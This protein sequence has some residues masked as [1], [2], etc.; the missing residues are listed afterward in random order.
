[1][2]CIFQLT[3]FVFIV[4][5]HLVSAL[6]EDQVNIFD[7]TSK[8]LGCP[9]K[10][11]VRGD[12]NGSNNIF[13]SS[14]N[15][16]G[17]IHMETGKLGWRH[18]NGLNVAYESDIFTQNQQLIHLLND[19]ALRSFDLNS[20][21]VNWQ[22]RFHSSDN[23]NEFSFTKLAH[24]SNLFAVLFRSE[25][26]YGTFS[27]KK[28]TSMKSQSLEKNTD[29]SDVHVYSNRI[30]VIGYKNEEVLQRSYDLEENDGKTK[31]LKADHP[32]NKCNFLGDFIICLSHSKTEKIVVFDINVD[33]AKSTDSLIA[34]PADQ[35]IPLNYGYF[36][37][38]SNKEMLVA[39]INQAKSVNVLMKFQRTEV[40]SITNVNMESR[41]TTILSTYHDETQTLRIYDLNA[42]RELGTWVLKNP[43]NP[44]DSATQLAPSRFVHVTFSSQN[45]VFKILIT[46]WDCRIDYYETNENLDHAILKWSR[47]EGLASINTVQM[48]DFPLSYAQA[49]IETEFGAPEESIWQSFVLRI[50]SQIEQFRH[51]IILFT[52]SIIK[53]L[54]LI[55]KHHMPISIV[56][57]RIFLPKSLIEKKEP[58]IFLHNVSDSERTYSE[59]KL[60]YNELERDFFNTRKVI[61]ATTLSGSLYGINNENG[62]VLWSFYLGLNAVPLLDEL[63]KPKIPLYIQRGTSHFQ[64]SGQAVAIFNSKDSPHSSAVVFNPIN[65]ELIEKFSITGGV[66]KAELLPFPNDE[67]IYPIVLL[68]K[69]TSKNVQFYPKLP[70]SY[71]P[72]Y[73]VYLFNVE[74]KKGL[75]TGYQILFES[76]ELI[77]SWRTRLPGFLEQME[78]NGEKIVAVQGKSLNQKMHSQG[79]V[80]GD[81]SVLYKYSNPNLIAVAS[82]N[83]KKLELHISL[84]DGVSGSLVYSGKHSRAQTPINLVLC[85]NWLTYSYWNERARRTELTVVE[86][87]EGLEQTNAKEFN[88][89]FPLKQQL[90]FAIQSY[91][92]PQG[93]TAMAVS[94]TDQGLALRN[95]LIALPFGGILEISRKF[96]DARRPMEMTPELREEMII[97]YIPELPINNEDFITYNQSILGVRAIK[98]SPSGLESTSLV[99]AY[100]IDLFYSRVTPSGAFDVLKDDFDYVLIFIVMVSLIL[101]T[102]LAKKIWRRSSIRQAWS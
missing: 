44:I 72:G 61:V 76:Q 97:P 3:L 2:W 62:Q 34:T 49:R 95:L 38:Q 25:L 11:L 99:F 79:K 24:S 4:E 93:V 20:G 60:Q 22:I 71:D 41:H 23:E 83:D 74:P 15:A 16:L 40:F 6:F 42:N 87:F 19:G 101:A 21:I 94:E 57:K 77:E 52:D 82:T 9:N 43:D 7:W 14:S 73:P 37:I 56:L 10:I 86:L 59:G 28:I 90:Q 102:F 68:S 17:Q 63:G 13:I 80:L 88:S 75:M 98:T 27:S 18:L 54:E 85:E 47:F 50:T 29:W 67:M 96:V 66:L 58:A 26:F 78:K 91:I 69:A 1:M 45:R 81:R 33:I 48:V 89:F 5:F 64:F 32:L 12:K 35:I 8:H 36:I 51:S 92:F 55:F 70:A 31:I 65:G 39:T 53:S 84:V 46:R 30:F 100:G